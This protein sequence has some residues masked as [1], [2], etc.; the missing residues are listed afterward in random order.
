MLDATKTITVDVLIVGAGGAGARAAL[1]VAG[2]GLRCALLCKEQ[3]GRA[4]TG[5]AEG[6]L[7]VALTEFN[8]RSTAE[9]HYADTLAGGAEINNQRLV[10]TFTAETPD[11]LRDLERY[12]VLFDR[13]DDGEI[14]QRFSGKQTYPL[15]AFIG[16]YTGR[17]IMSALTDQI[18]K[19]HLTQRIAVYEEHVVCELLTAEGAGGAGRVAGALVLDLLSG[20]L[21]HVRARAV[22]LA[23][24][25]GGRMYRVTTNAASNTGDGYALG[26]G[27]GAELVDMEMVQFHPTGM[28]HPESWRGVLVTESVRGEGGRLSNSVGERFMVR[29]QPERLE[30][31]GRDEVARAIF[32]EVGAGR[33]SPHGGVFL[34]VAHLDAAVIEERLPSMLHQFLATG[35]DIRREP[36][37]VHPSMHHM[38]GGLRIDVFGRTSVP[39]LYACGEVAGGIHGANRLGGNALAECQVFGRRSALGA[40]EFAADHALAATDGAAAAARTRALL[41]PRPDGVRPAAIESRLQALMWDRVGIARDAPGL[42]AARAGIQQ[43]REEAARM[44]PANAAP[45]AN[46]EWLACL[47]VRNMLAV[48][49]AIVAS[50][51]VRTESRGAHY[52]TDYPERDARWERNVVVRRDEDGALSTRVV[53][54][55]T[56]A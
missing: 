30:L 41:T 23:T 1:E 4:H 51:L 33:G 39:G 38:M 49:E 53:P 13:T 36:C 19:Q 31:A 34:S 9:T 55:T 5:M 40:A 10:R 6:G 3:L 15:T 50:A 25:G 46:A 12:G 16:D 37:E 35:V 43:L 17:E 26:L 44:A 47:E 28:V 8:P 20:A 11:R 52:R 32:A 22:I 14:A 48:A 29:Y 24:G 54:L 2:R 7:N 21:L 27:V 42:E 56:S 45:R 18:R